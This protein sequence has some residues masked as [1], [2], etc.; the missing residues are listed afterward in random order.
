MLDEAGVREKFGV[1]PRSIPDYLALVGDANDGI[2]GVP[3]WGAGTSARILSRYGHIEDI[4]PDP[5]EWDVAV[6]G[7]AAASASLEEHRERAA[8]LQA[9]GHPPHR[10]PH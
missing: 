4:P 8:P 7:A 5:A 2:P 6:R 9:A 1:G 3:R 10:R